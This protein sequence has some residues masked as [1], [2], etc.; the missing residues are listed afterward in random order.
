M[1]MQ[2]ATYAIFNIWIKDLSLFYIIIRII[3]SISNVG[4]LLFYV[5]I[6]VI[7]F[8]KNNE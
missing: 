1:Y 2:F 4:T 3:T 8:C 6:Q 5:I 7:F